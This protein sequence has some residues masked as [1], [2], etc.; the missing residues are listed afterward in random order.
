M[1]YCPS[2]KNIAQVRKIQYDKE[3]PVSPAFDLWMGVRG[4]MIK[5]IIWDF[6][7]TLCDTY[8]PI[9]RAM[10]A[11]LSTLGYSY[12]YGQILSL[13][14]ISMSHCLHTLAE[15][16]GI[17]FA[18]LDEEIDCQYA[19]VGPDEQKPFPGVKEI[20][21]KIQSGG[22][23][24]IIITH[25]RSSTLHQLLEFFTLSAYFEGC[26]TADDGFPRKPNP[27]A[28]F[29]A[30]QSYR[31]NPGETLGIGDRALDVEAAQASGIRSAFFGNPPQGLKPD[32]VIH[33]YFEF[34][35]KL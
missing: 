30:L 19:S 13:C 26:I 34:L 33:D 20:L 35:K 12:S 28:F 4:K 15:Q 2:D 10:Q 29:A 11:G 23:K 24:N 16:T 27:A 21:Q 7:G 18:E 5:H 17:P 32:Y 22:G 14:K 31:L 3:R 25:R 8:P 6:D 9:A 1:K